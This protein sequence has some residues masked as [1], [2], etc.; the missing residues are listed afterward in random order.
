MSAV[1]NNNYEGLEHVNIKANP[2]LCPN[3]CSS[4]SHFYNLKSAK[5]LK[6]MQLNI[7]TPLPNFEEIKHIV[8]DLDIDILSLNETRLDNS[9][10]DGHIN[11]DNYCLFRKHRNRS[12]GGIAL[13][14]QTS[15]SP[16]Q[17]TI[18]SESECICVYVKVK[19]L[20]VAVSNM[21]RPPSSNISYFRSIVNDIEKIVS[22]DYKVIILG[23]FNYDLS[24]NDGS[25]H[26]NVIL[27]EQL[28]D[29]KQLIHSPARVTPMTQNKL[30]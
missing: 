16:V 27:L 28:F 1:N 7:R 5:G 6:C 18:K 26:K 12:G 22:E 13:Y 21:Y 10:S 4:V 20:R 25:F 17:S 19:H 30:T 29:L 23:D 8:S 15:L 24:N 11:I 9:I 2:S 3:Y 14:I